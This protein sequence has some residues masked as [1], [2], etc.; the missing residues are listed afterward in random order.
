M[1]FEANCYTDVLG[2]EH[3]T[4]CLAQVVRHFGTREGAQLR[5]V[6]KYDHVDS[7]LGLPH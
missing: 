4:G 7:L 3:L 5:F 6:S 1:S 2:I